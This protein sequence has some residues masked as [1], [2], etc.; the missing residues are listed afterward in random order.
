MTLRVYDTPL[1]YILY[2]LTI[3][4]DGTFRLSGQ[5]T[6]YVGRISKNWQSMLGQPLAIEPSVAGMESEMDLPMIGKVKV[7]SGRIV[8]DELVDR[9]ADRV[10]GRIEFSLPGPDGPST[11]AGTFEVGVVTE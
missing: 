8:L 11:F 9:H 3:H 5:G 6:T 4:R 7:Q 2:A 1:D 10:K